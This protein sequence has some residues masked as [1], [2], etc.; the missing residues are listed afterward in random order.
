MLD[1]SMHR[2]FNTGFT[3]HKNDIHVH[4]SQWQYWWW[5]WFS[6]LWSLYFLVILRLILFGTED[7][8]N[9]TNTSLR[10]HGKW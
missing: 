3:S 8:K 4:L 5:F 2:N 7:Y 10:S 9:T 1:Y 6:L